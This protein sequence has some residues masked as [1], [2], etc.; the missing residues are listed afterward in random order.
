MTDPN[1]TENPTSWE[2]IYQN[3]VKHIRCLVCGSLSPNQ[4]YIDSLWCPSCKVYHPQRIPNQFKSKDEISNSKETQSQ[5]S[6]RELH[7]ETTEKNQSGDS[8]E[9]SRSNNLNRMS[10]RDVS[11]GHD[12]TVNKSENLLNKSHEVRENIIYCDRCLNE[13][14]P[15]Y[16]GSKYYSCPNG[17]S[18]I[19][20]NLIPI[21]DKSK[22]IKIKKSR[23]IETHCKFC[24]KIAEISLETNLGPN[25]KLRKYTCGHS[26]LIDLLAPPEDRDSRW[27][28]A[29]PFQQEGVEFIENSNYQALLADEMGLGK[30]MQ[31]LFALRYNYNELTPTLIVCEAA[32][33]YDWKDEFNE[34]VIKDNPKEFEIY[35]EP[36]IHTSGTFGLCPGFKT[37]II[38][39]ALL[40]KP[41]VLKSILEYGFK[42]VIVDESHS[43]KNEDSKRTSAIQKICQSIDHY[44]FLSGT[45]VMNKVEEFFTTLNILRPSHFPSKKSLIAKCDRTDSGKILGISKIYRER[46]F[47]MTSEYILRRTKKDIGI[48][49][50]KLFIHEKFVEVNDSKELVDAYNRGLDDLEEILNSK[51]SNMTQDILGIFS[52]LRHITGLMKV[53]TVAA[54]VEEFMESTEEDG[55]KI[56]VGIHHKLV[57]EFLMKRLNKYNPI[58]ISDEDGLTKA[59]KIES[60]KKPENRLLIASILGAGQGLNIQF[61]KNFVQAERQWNPAKEKQF[62]GR[63]HRIVKDANGNVVTEFTDD[64]AVIGDILNAKDT[65][66]EYFDAAVKLKEQ[67]VKT[68]EESDFE[69]DTSFMIELA[70]KMVQ[71]RMK[72]G[73]G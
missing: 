2:L 55:N 5:N 51:K 21:E 48:Q 63:F 22:D 25:R 53:N 44:I 67:I 14:K 39:M 3:G 11:N 26:E 20:S 16:V 4:L 49:L 30:T 70:R 56:C 29:F 62:Y 73:I 31:S 37:H 6:Q 69:T 54:Y 15:N 60:F 9:I 42:L 10:N 35:E 64:D 45:P 12:S 38:S 40:Q 33:V 65:L 28:K 19:I 61:C 57:G 36:L 41:K 66:D 1:L 72:H 34:W 7:N 32:K 27:V 68:T 58:T 24:G 17:H 8:G 47:K 50:P 43:F 59:N 71:V 23:K 13:M 46:F 18:A 52:N